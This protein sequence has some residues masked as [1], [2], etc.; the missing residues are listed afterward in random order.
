MKA[1][2][3]TVIILLAACVLV[4]VGILTGQPSLVMEKAAKVCM[5]CVGIG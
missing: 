1:G 5:E 2:R 3:I 4:A